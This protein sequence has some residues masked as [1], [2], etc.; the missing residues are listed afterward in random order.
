MRKN[1]DK[2]MPRPIGMEAAQAIE[3]YLAIPDIHDVQREKPGG[4]ITLSI[5]LITCVLE[6]VFLYAAVTGFITPL[7]GLM[8]HSAIV[9][10]LAICVRFMERGSEGRFILLLFISVIVTGPFGSAGVALSILIYLWCSRRALVFDEWFNSIF[11]KQIET[12]S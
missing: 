8:L 1:P 2:L 7:F 12:I 5:A 11:P 10:L 3:D 6:A 4:F 9:V